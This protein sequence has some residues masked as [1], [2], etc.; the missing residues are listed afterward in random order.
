[1]NQAVTDLAGI[2]HGGFVTV[3]CVNPV[4][5]DLGDGVTCESADRLRDLGFREGIRVRV[6]SRSDP[7]ICQVGGC[8]IGLCRSLAKCVMVSD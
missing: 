3:S 4:T 8:R 7:M 5:G 6:I 1:M 2:G